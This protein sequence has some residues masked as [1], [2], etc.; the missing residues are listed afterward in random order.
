[1][2]HFSVKPLCFA[3]IGYVQQLGMLRSPRKTH[4]VGA[5]DTCLPTGLSDTIWVVSLHAFDTWQICIV[6]VLVSCNDMHSC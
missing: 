6:G 5:T 1:M 3:S 4:L 2:L